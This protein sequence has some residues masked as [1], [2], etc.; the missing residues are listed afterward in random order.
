M[1]DFFIKSGFSLENVQPPPFENEQP[2]TNS[3]CWPMELQVT[4]LLN[5]F[6]YFNLRK[7]ILKRGINNGMSGSSWH[8]NRFLYINVKILSVGDKLFR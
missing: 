2:F 7:S 8:F 6:V 5:N 1:E 4:K 3:R